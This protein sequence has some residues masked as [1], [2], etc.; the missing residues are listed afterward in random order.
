MDEKIENYENIFQFW[1]ESSSD[2]ILND[3]SGN[4]QPRQLLA[5]ACVS[6]KLPTQSRFSVSATV[7]ERTDFLRYHNGHCLP[8][9]FCL[10]HSNHAPAARTLCSF[11]LSAM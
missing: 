5:R 7:S 11:R 2:L 8:T 1:K 10:H 6:L 4:C 3:L 9:H